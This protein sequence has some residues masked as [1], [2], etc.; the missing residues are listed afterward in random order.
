MSQGPCGRGRCASAIVHVTS[1]AR[2][3]TILLVMCPLLLE[4]QLRELMQ[5]A[6]PAQPLVSRQ[7]GFIVDGLY[8]GLSQIVCACLG[9]SAILPTAV[10]RKHELDLLLEVG[11]V[12]DL[13]HGD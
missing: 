2:T 8:A 5:A 12:F 6:P 11:H 3:A 9:G 1:T 7:W 4:Q 13:R 10:A